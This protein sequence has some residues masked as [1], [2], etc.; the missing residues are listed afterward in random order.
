MNSDELVVLFEV[1]TPLGFSVR[2]TYAYWEFIVT[3][4][5][6]IMQSRLMEVQETLVQPDEVRLSRTDPQ[7]YLFY[8]KDGTNRWVCAVTKRLE[9]SGFLITTYRTSAIKEG[10]LLWQR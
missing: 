9:D 6:P 7:I 4:K 10:D 1:T 2:T 8:R 5:H 3:V